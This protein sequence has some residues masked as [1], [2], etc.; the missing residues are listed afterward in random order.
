MLRS[1]PNSPSSP[2]L[3]LR[4]KGKSTH[5]IEK[6]M[7]DDIALERERAL[8]ASKKLCIS[9]RNKNSELRKELLA[10]QAKVD[11]LS[12]EK[13]Q[14]TQKIK[15]LQQ[16]NATLEKYL[17]DQF[18]KTGG[19]A[20]QLVNLN[21]QLI[22]PTE[23]GK[24]QQTQNA[25]LFLKEKNDSLLNELQQAKDLIQNLTDE[26]KRL[27]EKL[28][29]Q[30]TEN[31][32]KEENNSLLGSQQQVENLLLQTDDNITH[33][34]A[35][36]EENN[37]FLG[38]H[39]KAEHLPNLSDGNL[40]HLVADIDNPYKDPKEI[41]DTWLSKLQQ[42]TQDL[43]L[44]LTEENKKLTERLAKQNDQKKTEEENVSLVDKPQ[45]DDIVIQNEEAHGPTLIYQLRVDSLL[46]KEKT[47]S[48][49]SSSAPPPINTVNT[50][51]SPI[52]HPI[53][54]LPSSNGWKFAFIGLGFAIGAAAVVT[55]IYALTGLAFLAMMTTVAIGC[56][57]G[58]GGAVWCVSIR[59][60][61]YAACSSNK[62]ALTKSLTSEA[63][64][65]KIRSLPSSPSNSTLETLAFKKG[66]DGFRLFS[67]NPSEASSP[68][69]VCQSSV[70]VMPA[71]V[72]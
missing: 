3:E 37:L 19:L 56:T 39:Q 27:N 5:E 11:A 50:N 47:D 46:T 2:P 63:S 54:P 25:A 1:T 6:I 71:R 55:G 8:E 59:Y 45:P 34:V 21:D 44:N 15:S 35:D 9:Y 65:P 68:A 30:H 7:K 12:D 29:K 14:L 33:L 4:I 49:V 23:D 42:Q 24:F 70:S 13:K 57:I 53:K 67:K 18:T 32:I 17:A 66:A 22:N 28:T 16:K 64:K 72:K 20:S 40:V 41:N 58:I 69:A 31:I 60:A 38:S 10:E 43:I 26:S 51:N 62:S 61:I 48:L 36:K 52:D